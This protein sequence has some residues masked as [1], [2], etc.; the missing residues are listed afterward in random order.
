M[1]ALEAARQWLDGAAPPTTNL[2]GLVLLSTVASAQGDGARAAMARRRELALADGLQAEVDASWG[3][4]V[5]PAS[6][7][8]AAMEA[9]RRARDDARARRRAR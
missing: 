8:P 7:A 1:V 9:A 4:M 3:A 6:L 2:R 5:H